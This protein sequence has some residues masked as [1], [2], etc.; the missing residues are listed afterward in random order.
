MKT[1]FATCIVLVYLD[2]GLTLCFAQSVVQGSVTISGQSATA[3]TGHSV[4]LT[5]NASQNATAYNIYRG[6]AHGGPYLKVASGIAGTTYNDIQVTDH[7]TLYYVTTAVTG[8]S[9][10]GYSNEAIAVIP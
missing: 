5:W 1:V 4:T 8:N 9:E 7:Q 6:A 2:F 3:T 10:S